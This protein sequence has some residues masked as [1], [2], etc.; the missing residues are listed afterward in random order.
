MYYKK[1]VCSFIK[2]FA[3]YRQKKMK[4]NTEQSLSAD[5]EDAD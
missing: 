3:I 5:I 1:H 4:E 2:I